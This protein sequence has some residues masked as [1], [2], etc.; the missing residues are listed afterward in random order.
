VF[1]YDHVGPIDAGGD[2]QAHAAHCHVTPG[3]CADA[4]VSAGPGQFVFSDAL[5]VVPALALVAIVVAS[6]TLVGRVPRPAPRPPLAV[7]AG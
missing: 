4:P 1:P 7:V 2:A 3:S 6:A 5:L